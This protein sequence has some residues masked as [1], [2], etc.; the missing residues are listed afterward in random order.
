MT[1]R[2]TLIT[3]RGV[4][5]QTLTEVTTQVLN[6][7]DRRITIHIESAGHTRLVKITGELDSVSREL[8][9][10]QCTEGQAR[11]VVVDLSELTFLDSRGHQAFVDARTTL[12]RHHR[13]LTL[14]G[15]VGEPLR[16]LDLIRRIA[17]KDPS[18]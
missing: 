17:P 3:S 1:M 4:L 11:D 18:C 8:V 16:L 7:D 6:V 14:V 9:T 10:R 13:T 12:G 5:S 2:T 15:A